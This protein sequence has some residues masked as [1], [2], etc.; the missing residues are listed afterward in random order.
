MNSFRAV[1]RALDYEAERQYREWQETGQQAG[2]RAQANPRLGRRGRRHPRP[3]AQGRIE[4]LPLLSR[5][6]PGAG[7]DDRRAKSTQCATS[8]GEL[9][10]ALR[11]RLS[12][13][14][15]LSAYDTDV[16]VNQGRAVVDYYLAVGRR[17]EGSQGGVQLGHA[18]SAPRA[19]GAR[20][21]RSSSSASRPASLAGLIT[22]IN[23][24]RLPSPRASEAFQ[25]MLAKGCA[26]RRGARRAQDRA[27]RRI[28]TCRAGRASC[29]PPIPKRSPT[30]RRASCK[31]PAPSSA[32]RRRKTPTST[33]TACAS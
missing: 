13:D 21:G 20:A 24:G 16:L 33:P 10:A 7:D 26:R 22:A 23:D 2:R 3:A 19:Q 27:G 8:L 32:R 5:S 11:N 28:R 6:R 31:P 9:P 17:V 15:G 1:E 25:L 12:D 4:R 30:S 14:Y 18:G 29:W